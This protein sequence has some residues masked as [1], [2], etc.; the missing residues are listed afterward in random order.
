MTTRQAITRP[1]TG[2]GTTGGDPTTATALLLAVALKLA[3]TVTT[4]CGGDAGRQGI[5]MVAVSPVQ[6]TA[7]ESMEMAGTLNQ[8][9]IQK[10]QSLHATG[11]PTRQ[12]ARKLEKNRGI[13]KAANSERE[14]AKTTAITPTTP[15]PAADTETAESAVRQEQAKRVPNAIDE[16]WRK[17]Q[18]HPG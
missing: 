15:E 6:A 18:G 9:E 7:G 5:T 13:A 4:A 16:A 11:M 1:Q 12:I 8:T 2:P 14:E 17:A 3:G 10:I